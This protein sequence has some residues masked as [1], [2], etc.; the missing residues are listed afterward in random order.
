MEM[1]EEKMGVAVRKK[2]KKRVE[3]KEG[4]IEQKKKKKKD[5]S[6]GICKL[7]SVLIRISFLVI[8]ETPK[9]E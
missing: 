7:C 1:W 8:S 2:R 5:I 3:E 6:L 9:L 4:R